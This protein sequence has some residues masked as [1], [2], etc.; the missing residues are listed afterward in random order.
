MRIPRV[1]YVSEDKTIMEYSYLPGNELN[2]CAIKILDEELL[3]IV[4]EQLALFLG[5]LQ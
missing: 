2:A 5:D 1:T 4:S 3:G